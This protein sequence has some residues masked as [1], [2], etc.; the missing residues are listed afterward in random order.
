MESDTKLTKELFFIEHWQGVWSFWVRHCLAVSNDDMVESDTGQGRDLASGPPTKPN[1]CLPDNA[2]DAQ[3][4]MSSCS[5]KPYQT[6]WHEGLWKHFVWYSVKCSMNF[7]SIAMEVLWTF[8]Y[9]LQSIADIRTTRLP[10]MVSDT[11]GTGLPS[12][13]VTSLGLGCLHGQWHP[14]D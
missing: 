4:G 5:M 13:L 1:T 11:P 14:W 10:L 12:W 2:A 8:L 7:V 3:I 6:I 9:L